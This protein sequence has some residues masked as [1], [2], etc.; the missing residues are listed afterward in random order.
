MYTNLAALVLK[1][2]VESSFSFNWLKAFSPLYILLSQD[3]TFVLML[4]MNLDLF[5]E[6]M[7]GIVEHGWIKWVIRI[8]QVTLGFQ[9]LL[10]TV[11]P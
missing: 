1:N 11:P 5:V 4:I 9:P 8:R 2:C 6:V 7:S 3:L 10:V